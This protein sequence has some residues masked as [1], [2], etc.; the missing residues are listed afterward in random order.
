MRYDKTVPFDG[1]A[2]RA[3]E[4]AVAVLTGLGFR[5]VERSPTAIE[6]SGPGMNSSRESGLMGA[7]RIRIAGRT[8]ELALEAELGGVLRM[9][10]FVRYFPLALSLGLFLVLAVVFW[11]TMRH[12]MGDWWIWPL[13]GALAINV[14]LWMFLGPMMSRMIERRTRQ[15]L[16][17]LLN[18]MALAAGE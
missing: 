14:V 17:A 9:A 10:K 1:D 13:G 12:P 15:A 18:N 3:F 8:R 5:L 6:F 2:V 11:A 7:T 4:V 16:D